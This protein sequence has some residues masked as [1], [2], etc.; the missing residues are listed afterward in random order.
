MPEEE[1][2]KRCSELPSYCSK[3]SQAKFQNIQE[4][5]ALKTEVHNPEVQQYRSLKRNKIQFYRTF[6]VISSALGEK[7]E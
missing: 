1:K 3:S 2:I 5:F 4:S 7:K 6:S